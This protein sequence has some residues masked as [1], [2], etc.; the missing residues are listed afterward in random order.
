M[1]G[2]LS[3]STATKEQQAEGAFYSTRLGVK[4]ADRRNC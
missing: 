1:C 4:R 3:F 2:P